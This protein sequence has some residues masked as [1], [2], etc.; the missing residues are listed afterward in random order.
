MCTPLR[1]IQPPP[2]PCST[3]K[4]LAI[5]RLRRFGV[6]LFALTEITVRL[7]PGSLWVSEE[8]VGRHMEPSA[9]L[10]HH[11]K[12]QKHISNDIRASLSVEI[13]HQ[14]SYILA[15]WV[16]F[17]TWAATSCL[18]LPPCCPTLCVFFFFIT[19]SSHSD[20]SIVDYQEIVNSGER[21]V[22]NVV[23]TSPSGFNL[24]GMR[25]RVCVCI[26]GLSPLLSPLCMCLLSPQ[27]MVAVVISPGN[28]MPYPFAL[29]L[30]SFPTL[31]SHPIRGQQRF[32]LRQGSDWLCVSPGWQRGETLIV[33]LRIGKIKLEW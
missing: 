2:C 31:K 25:V 15:F 5:C 18:S 24:K 26:K 4:H 7:S 3:V 12:T 23:N 22:H 20:S 27:N 19:T 32:P 6:I 30:K 1:S 11:M 13:P 33:L 17:T 10:H 9:C 28:I 29:N 14:W 16:L 21:Q 8:E